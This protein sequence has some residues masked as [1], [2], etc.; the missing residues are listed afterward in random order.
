MGS[1]SSATPVAAWR[2]RQ[3]SWIAAAA[4]AFIASSASSALA[5]YNAG[6]SGIH[7][8]FPPAA[9]PPATHYVLWNLKSGLVR[10]CETYDT[11]ARPDT[12]IVEISAA[13]IPGIPA[14][15]LTTG[16]YQFTNFDL[17]NA[18]FAFNPVELYAVGHD[19]PVPLTILSQGSF[20]LYYVHFHVS[21]GVGGS[22]TTGL[23]PTG[24]GAPGGRSGPGGFAGGNG[25]KHGSPSTGGNGGFGPTGGAGGASNDFTATTGRGA[26][27]AP[28]PVATSLTPLV[29]G[30]GGGGGGA[31]DT[32]CGFRGGGGGG[33]GG[34]GALLVAANG[35][36]ILEGSGALDARGGAGGD[37]CL[38]GDGGAGSGG[39]VRLAASSILG[40]GQIYV[41]NGIVRIE[42]NAST[43]SGFIDT[44]RG[45]VLA[46]PQPAIPATIPTLRITS[47]GGIAVG[48]S[49]SGSIATPDVTFPTAPSGPVTVN[50]AGANIP[51]GAA[52][53]IRANPLIGTPTTA[54]SS[55]TGSTASSTASA[56]LEIP[57]GAG[58]IT[59]VTSFPVTTAMLDRLP[60]IPGMKPAL[61]EVTADASGT[62]RM[63]LIG[64][65][66]K[67]VE[68]TMGANGVFAVVP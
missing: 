5:Q 23:P 30:A 34:G 13:Q 16:V 33:G 66:S 32:F 21:G 58:V 26:D 57:A 17:A 18:L 19:G 31:Y 1:R 14:G 48:Q 47:V 53:Q 7:G 29:G 50:L 61:I 41:G 8:A 62:S 52:V 10:Y 55:L 67:R 2:R 11:V 60:A 24:F 63:F 25:G 39:S 42:G 44:T 40:T 9:M 15:G 36:I 27:A 4:V 65:D 20:R 68:L 28:S 56:S 59:A 43:Y 35:Q 64:E 54:N 3:R 38:Y 51:T 37:G 22:T 6:S 12:C 45:T 49:P 46:A